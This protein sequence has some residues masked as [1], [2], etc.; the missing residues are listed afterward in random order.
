MRSTGTAQGHVIVLTGGKV[1][2]AE[3]WASPAGKPSFTEEGDD[4]ST[5]CEPSSTTRFDGILKNAVALPAFRNIAT[6]IKAR[7]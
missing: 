6:K 5:T 4:Y 2:S 3:G 7:Q 1:F